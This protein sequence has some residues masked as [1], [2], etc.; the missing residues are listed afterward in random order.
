MSSTGVSSGGPERRLCPGGMRKGGARAGRAADEGGGGLL[1]RPWR[2]WNR[3]GVRPSTASLCPREFPFWSLTHGNTG[4][5]ETD[6]ANVIKRAPA[7]RER[8]N[9]RVCNRK[10]EARVMTLYIGVDIHAR[11]RTV[12]YLDTED[13]TIGA[14]GVYTMNEM[15]LR[16]LVGC[17]QLPQRHLCCLCPL[18]L[19][20]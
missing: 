16:R 12:S 18:S 2:G 3:V 14:A 11:Q 9:S 19:C 5:C 10:K 20:G 17:G 8:L 4:H 15:T 1:P 7:N 6:N 13:W